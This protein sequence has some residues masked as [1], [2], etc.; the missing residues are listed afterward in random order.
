MGKTLYQQIGGPAA[1]D[2]AVGVFYR[3]LRTD[4]SIN[5]FFDD[6][7]ARMLRAIQKDF[8]IMAMGGPNGYTGK[9]VRRAHAYLVARGLDDTH[10]DRVVQHLKST[11]EQLRVPSAVAAQI[12]ATAGTLRADI[13]TPPTC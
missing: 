12:L 13:A 5:R 8:L 4:S 3:K 1:I 10:I 11:L 7:D 6:I 2:V 9:D